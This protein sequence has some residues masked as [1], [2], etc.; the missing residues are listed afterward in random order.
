MIAAPRSDAHNYRCLM[1][2]RPITE[3]GQDVLVRVLVVP[4]ASSTGIVGRHGDRIRV[5]VTAAPERGR[6]NAAVCSVLCNATGA[7]EAEVVAGAGNRN[8]TVRLSHVSEVEV[9]RLLVGET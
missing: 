3:D 6:A 7:R 1:D 5:R 2:L 9:A 8:K 4:N